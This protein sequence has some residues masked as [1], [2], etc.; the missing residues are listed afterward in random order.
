MEREKKDDL[1]EEEEEGTL[2]VAW[3]GCWLLS[4]AAEEDV[5]VEEELETPE[6]DDENAEGEDPGF[7][8]AC[9][10]GTPRE[11]EDAGMATKGHMSERKRTNIA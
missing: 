6:E 3:E 9:C 7:A 11:T 4:V 2:G 10:G 1:P 5:E 8:D